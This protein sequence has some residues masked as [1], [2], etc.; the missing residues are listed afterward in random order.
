MIDLDFHELIERFDEIHEAVERGETFSVFRA[1]G[2]RS[3]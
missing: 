3:P 2:V 1:T